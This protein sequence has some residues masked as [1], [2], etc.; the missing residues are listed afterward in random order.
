MRPRRYFS[1]GIGGTDASL[2]VLF[3]PSAH[4]RR[5]QRRRRQAAMARFSYQAQRAED[6]TL[7]NFL[8][9]MVSA[10]ASPTTHHRQLIAD[11]AAIM[12]D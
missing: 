10:S 11:N 3:L 7:P 9:L 2:K 6:N 8:V 4:S 1:R 5:R 12:M